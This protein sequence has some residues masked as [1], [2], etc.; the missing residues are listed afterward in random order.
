MSGVLHVDQ[1]DNFPD[2]LCKSQSEL[3]LLSSSPDRA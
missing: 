2:L 3:G 1:A